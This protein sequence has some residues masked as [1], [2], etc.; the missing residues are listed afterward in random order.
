LKKILYILL[1]LPLLLSSAC[2]AP[3]EEF[4]V[5]NPEEIAKHIKIIDYYI[6]KEPGETSITSKSKVVV[7]YQNISD[8]VIGS[9]FIYVEYLDKD[10]NAIGSVLLADELKD[11]IISPNHV[12]VSRQE[13]FLGSPNPED[14][15]GKEWNGDIQ[16]KIKYIRTSDKT[17]M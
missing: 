14:I 3:Q 1:L 4:Y 15:Y 16:P 8:K 10:G 7:K 11:I 9:V 12:K 13:L 2:S 5:D 6:E 17:S